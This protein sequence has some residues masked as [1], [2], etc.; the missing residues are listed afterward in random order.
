MKT[1]SNETLVWDTSAD[2][3]Y[4]NYQNYPNYLN[5][6]ADMVPELARGPSL[7]TRAGGQDD[8]SL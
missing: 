5:N 2:P 4:A 1:A 6:L 7:T 3:N 8:V